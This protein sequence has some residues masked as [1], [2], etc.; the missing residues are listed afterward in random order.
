MH[1]WALAEAVV[2]AVLAQARSRPERN[3]RRV[4][5]VFGEL[6]SI[7]SEVF[8]T[9]LEELCRN[10]ELSGA[11]FALSTREAQLRCR[12]CGEEWFLSQ[13]QISEEER[14]SIHFLPEVVHAFVACPQ[15]GSRDFEV[16]EGRG[17]TVESIEYDGGED[18]GST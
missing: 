5:V 14:E 17:V 4:S 2:E 7:D 18:S 10:S 12:A 16:Q 11:E 3:V 13:S 15:C 1:E 9:G 8:A 6:Q